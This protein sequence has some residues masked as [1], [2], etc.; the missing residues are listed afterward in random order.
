MKY[1]KKILFIMRLI[2]LC[3]IL[4]CVYAFATNNL[5]L[6]ENKGY[7]LIPFVIIYVMLIFIQL[8]M[9]HKNAGRYKKESDLKEEKSNG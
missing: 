5:N 6:L 9:Y 3:A 1:I 8:W 7:Y 4:F 2:A